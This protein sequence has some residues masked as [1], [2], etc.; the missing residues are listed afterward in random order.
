MI[1]SWTPRSK[2]ASARSD[3]R[4]DQATIT[5]NNRMT[6][7]QSAFTLLEMLLTRSLC[8]V[9]MMLVSGAMSFYVR[10]MASAETLFRQSQVASAVLQMI[11]DDLRTT[12]TTRP[13]DT[14]PL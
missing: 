11:E 10:Q 2:R 12:L 13:I 5:T 14:A 8:V 7:N 4:S 6:N 1:S 3:R 9:L